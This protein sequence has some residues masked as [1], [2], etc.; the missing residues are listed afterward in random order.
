MEGRENLWG[1]SMYKWDIQWQKGSGNDEVL[2][3][4]AAGKVNYF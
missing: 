4:M 3:D 2:P 1:N